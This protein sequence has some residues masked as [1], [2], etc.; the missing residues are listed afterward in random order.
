MAPSKSKSKDAQLKLDISADPLKVAAAAVSKLATST[1]QEVESNATLALVKAMR[2][3]AQGSAVIVSL[4][5][6]AM[7]D[8]PQLDKTP[9]ELDKMAL[10]KLE[11]AKGHVIDSIK[12]GEIASKLLSSDTSAM[13]KFAKL[14]AEA[15]PMAALMTFAA[16]GDKVDVT[17]EE[18][19][20]LSDAVDRMEGVMTGMMEMAMGAM[21]DPQSIKVSA[22]LDAFGKAAVSDLMVS[23][24]NDLL[25]GLA[26]LMRGGDEQGA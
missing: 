23:A 17:P 14:I 22:W 1:P 5:G 16:V 24:Q 3:A 18:D 10:D 19:K 15:T 9:E 26:G 21:A 7:Q 8:E 13:G 6:L 20:L 25:K 11:E 12:Y 2:S 4:I